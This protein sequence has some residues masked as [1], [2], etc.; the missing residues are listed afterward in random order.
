M[1]HNLYYVKSWRDH[2]VLGPC[3]AVGRFPLARILPLQG[4][5]P[6]RQI[7][8]WVEEAGFDG[9]N[10][11]EIFSTERWATDQA[12]YVDQIKQAYLR[13]A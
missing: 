6:L 10:E 5:I 11:V 4:C 3:S 13:H 2:G 12:E 8:S 9:F 7:R 1:S